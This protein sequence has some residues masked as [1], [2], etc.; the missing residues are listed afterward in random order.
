MWTRMPLNAASA[1][2]SGCH[3]EEILPPGALWAGAHVGL[4]VLLHDRGDLVSAGYWC[5]REML[6][7]LRATVNLLGARRVAFLR[8]FAFPDRDRQELIG[9]AI[10]KQVAGNQ[11]FALKGTDVPRPFGDRCIC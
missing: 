4:I 8:L 3:A 2:A 5:V 7:E 10:E 11:P 1:Y 6:H 9:A